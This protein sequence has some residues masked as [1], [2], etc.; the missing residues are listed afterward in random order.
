MGDAMAVSPPGFTEAHRQTIE[1]NERVQ[2]LICAR[3][4]DSWIYV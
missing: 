3:L 2:D 4:N 1:G